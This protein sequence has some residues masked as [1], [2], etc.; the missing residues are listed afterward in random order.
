M[1]TKAERDAAIM[2]KAIRRASKADSMFLMAVVL[3]FNEMAK[4]ATRL[5]DKVFFRLCRSMAH[6]A[7]KR[8]RD[9]KKWTV[10]FAGSSEEKKL[11]EQARNELRQNATKRVI[12]TARLVHLGW[13]GCGVDG[14]KAM[15]A[16]LVELTAAF[17]AYDAE[18]K[19]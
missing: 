14:E 10:K 1:K 13:L 19:E 7:L 2:E 11:R 6:D 17:E 9:A 4:N 12:D 5:G 15:R 18:G 8:S 3:G 16:S